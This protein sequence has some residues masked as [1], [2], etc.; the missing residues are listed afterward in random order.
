MIVAVDRIVELEGVR[1]QI[2]MMETPDGH[3]GLELVPLSRC[4]G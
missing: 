2:A 4:T 3:G 1:A